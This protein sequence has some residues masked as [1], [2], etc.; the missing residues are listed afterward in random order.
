MMQ[1]VGPS[2]PY[3]AAL[4]AALAVLTWL[5]LWSG[6]PKARY[7]AIGLLLAAIAAA[8][9]VRFDPVPPTVAVYSPLKPG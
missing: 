1:G 7:V 4:P 6:I 9:W 5:P 3:V 8:L 2:M